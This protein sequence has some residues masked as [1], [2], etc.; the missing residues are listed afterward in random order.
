M[1][2]TTGKK[3][4]GRQRGTPNKT[5]AQIK[6][7]I[8]EAFEQAGGVDYLVD[9]AKENPSVFVGLL[10]KIIPRDISVDAVIDK[11]KRTKEEIESQLLALGI[12]PSKL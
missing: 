7:A 12:D 6:T 1:A 10:G 3:F 5:T 9:L 2:N 4:G 8:I 11:P